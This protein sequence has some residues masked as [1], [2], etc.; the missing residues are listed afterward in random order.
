M[1]ARSARPRRR[2]T[3]QALLDAE[4]REAFQSRITFN[5]VLGLR[6]PSTDSPKASMALGMTPPLVGRY[7]CGRLHG[8]VISAVL[9]TTGGLALTC[10]IA[11]HLGDERATQILARFKRIGTI[12]LR[13][14][15]PRQV[16]RERFT[17]SASVTRLGCRVGVGLAN[18]GH[19]NEWGLLIAIGAGAYVVS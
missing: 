3:E 5:D 17:A 8:G 7:P 1:T 2:P 16:I 4:L 13:I 19:L 9:E 18:M 11:E 15:F 10:N 14:G 6:S 12:D